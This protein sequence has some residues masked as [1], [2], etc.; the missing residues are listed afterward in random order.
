[1]PVPALRVIGSK[2]FTPVERR[3][4]MAYTLVGDQSALTVP[5]GW[6]ITKDLEENLWRLGERQVLIAW[7]STVAKIGPDGQLN[8][9]PFPETDEELAEY[10]ALPDG[11]PFPA[12]KFPWWQ[13]N[14]IAF[15]TRPVDWAG[16]IQWWYMTQIEFSRRDLIAAFGEAV[17]ALTGLPLD[18]AAPLLHTSLVSVDSGEESSGSKAE[19]I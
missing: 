16:L 14:G 7:Q 1:M 8:V 12:N 18:V 10:L 5:L 6:P 11:K 15:D 17:E 4:P 3:D 13:E 9:F 2:S 19:S